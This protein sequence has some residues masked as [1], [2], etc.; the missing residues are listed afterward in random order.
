V[1]PFCP[2]CGTQYGA[3]RGGRADA[4]VYGAYACAGVSLLFFPIV[5]GPVGIVLAA[6]AL[7]RKEPHAVLALSLAIA[8]MVVGLLLGALAAL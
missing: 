4:L 7:G 6:I 2:E 3:L 1:K 5:C 8:G